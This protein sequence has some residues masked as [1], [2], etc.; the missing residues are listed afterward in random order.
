MLSSEKLIEQMQRSELSAV[1]LADQLSDARMKSPLSA[2]GNW[3]RGLMKPAP[4]QEDIAQLAG[5]LQCE[6]TEL[7]CWQASH[8]YA[9]MAPRKMRLVADLVRHY[10]VQE[11]MDLLKFA[12]KRAAVYIEQVLK[13]AVQNAVVQSD[14]DP[15]QLYVAE[16]RIDEGGVRRGTRRWRPKDRG[17]A[18]SFTRLASHIHITVDIITN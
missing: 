17:R 9:P 11:A 2:I 4:R 14:V 13:S 6:T 8:M 18:V 16:I 15:G 12:N 10:P 1:E 5:A 3:C 7:M